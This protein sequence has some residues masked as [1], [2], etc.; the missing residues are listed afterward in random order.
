[1]TLA[2]GFTVIGVVLIFF[3][4][5]AVLFF[6]LAA[7]LLAEESRTIAGGLDWLELRIRTLWRR[8]LSWW[9]GRSA[10]KS[11]ALAIA[12]CLGSSRGVPPLPL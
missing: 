10:A 3:P 7:A 8:A 9:R 2:S 1:M 4:G 12:A 5:P 11:L 6:F